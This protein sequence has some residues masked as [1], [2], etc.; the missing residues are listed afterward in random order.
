M[1]S[2][3]EK[4]ALNTKTRYLSH[5][6]LNC[7]NVKSFDSLWLRRMYNIIISSPLHLENANRNKIFSDILKAFEI[8]HLRPLQSRNFDS[9]QGKCLNVSQC[10][11]Q[12][13]CTEMFY[14]C[15]EPRILGMYN[16]NFKLQISALSLQQEQKMR[17]T[18]SKFGNRRVSCLDYSNYA[19]S[20]S[21]QWKQADNSFLKVVQSR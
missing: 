13:Y 17:S 6:N 9:D 5:Q 3:A 19:G 8:T 7:G 21:G 20:P 14:R 10:L 1:S 16:E 15:K 4:Y 18:Q 11:H 12:G 2:Q